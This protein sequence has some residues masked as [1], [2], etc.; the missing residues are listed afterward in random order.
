MLHNHLNEQKEDEAM[1]RILCK[2]MNAI[3]QNTSNALQKIAAAV[4]ITF[5]QE[6]SI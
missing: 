6:K 2:Q 5:R 1:Q 4:Q 3:T